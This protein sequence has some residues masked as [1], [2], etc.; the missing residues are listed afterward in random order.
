M[1]YNDDNSDQ[2]MS[3]DLRQIYAKL[4][5]DHMQDVAI[6]RKN[7]DNQEYFRALEDLY[8]IV[9]Y[10]FKKPK[11][12][13]EASTYEQLRKNVI[14]TAN[15]YPSAWSG[16]GTEPKEVNEVEMALRDVE[17]FLYFKMNESS[18]FGSKRDEGL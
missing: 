8:T 12:D 14:D 17:R 1:D 13:S 11:K 10:K 6:H 4:V 15:K 18:M 9:E 5:G 3:Y 7:R 2:Q 16:T